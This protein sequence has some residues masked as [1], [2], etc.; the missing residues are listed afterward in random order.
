[1]DVARE[2]YVD[3]SARRR[4]ERRL[5]AWFRHEQFAIRG[6]LVSTTHH[7]DMRVASVAAQTDD[8]VL[9]ATCAA[10]PAPALVTEYVAPS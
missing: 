1:M 7:G 8:E 4:R 3:G 9:A 2:L 10:T 6:A 5:R